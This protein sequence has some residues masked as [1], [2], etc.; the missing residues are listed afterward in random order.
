MDNFSEFDPQGQNH[1]ALLRHLAM[2]TLQDSV[3]FCNQDF[4]EC[5]MGLRTSGTSLGV[6]FYDGPHDYRSQLMGLLLAA[7]L[8]AERA[9]V[10]V[11]DSNWA[12]VKQATRDFLALHSQCRVLFD[13]PTPGNCHPTFWNG[14]LVLAWE[15]SSGLQQADPRLPARQPA[16]LASLHALQIV[17]LDVADGKIRL[18]PTG[19]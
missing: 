4:E 8:L 6:Y 18:I 13:L 15:R 14:L 10:V 12:A 1:A 19:Q 7:P 3:R 17:N 5:L 9:L 16:L 2:Y 11:D